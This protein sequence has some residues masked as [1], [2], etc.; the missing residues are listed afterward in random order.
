MG[1]IRVFTGTMFA[2]KTTRLINIAED[3]RLN[4]NCNYSVYRPQ[5]NIVNGI[6]AVLTHNHIA[7]QAQPLQD[8]NILINDPN[9]YIFIDSFQNLPPLFVDLIEKL[10]IDQDKEFYLFG[11]RT[12]TTGLFQETAC[13]MMSIADEIE[14]LPSKCSK[15]GQPA[16]YSVLKPGIKLEDDINKIQ[17]EKY[18]ILC[19]KCFHK[20]KLN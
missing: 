17:G 18:E 14:I 11:T 12:T 6:G 13:K 15:C 19:K 7:L 9:K 1:K 3:L 4:H 10:A 8:P 2:G 20:L 5:V 16:T